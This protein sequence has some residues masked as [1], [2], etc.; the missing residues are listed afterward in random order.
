[1]AKRIAAK[2]PWI[3]EAAVFAA[4]FIL[5]FPMAAGSNFADPD[6]HY[7]LKISEM[8]AEG[9]PV[10]SFGWM[11][12]TT[13][14]NSYADHHFLYHL[15]LVPFIKIFGPLAG[16]KTA[17]VVFASAAVAAVSWGMRRLGMRYA[18][19]WAILA[20]LMNPFVFR[21]GLAKASAPGVILLVAGLVL[22]ILKKRWP[23]AAVSFIYVWT[24]GGWPAL[25]ILGSAAILIV[26]W[27][28]K[29]DS[30]LWVKIRGLSPSLGALWGGTVAGLIINPFFPENLKF[31][32]QQIVQIAVVNY[33]NVI[34]VGNEWY[35]YAFSSLVSDLPL[36]FILLGAAIAAF[37]V[38]VADAQ[39]E[40]GKRRLRMLLALSAAAFLFL[41]MTLRSRRH[42][43]YFVPLAVMAAGSWIGQLPWEKTRP[44]MKKNLLVA[45]LLAAFLISAVGAYGR[46]S[47]A[48]AK[49]DLDG[50]YG[51]ELYKNASNYIAANAS[52]G[53]I[54]IHAD[55]DQMP[56]LF[57]WNSNNRYMMGL[58]PTFMYN[59]DRDRYWRYVN[60]TMGKSPNPAET[61]R[62]FN[63]R[64]V[65]SD[66]GHRALNAMLERSGKFEKIYSDREAFIYRLK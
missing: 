9:G 58:D 50:R 17:T 30:P 25:L 65:L 18:P 43:E 10:R 8:I 12:F 60:F 14:A 27:T 44:F 37:P 22:A 57:Y 64:F 35:P 32:W 7:H 5:Y 61:M 24:H 1:M 33:Q 6:A 26:S 66:D 19:L 2:C 54:I 38:I 11:P 4:V 3:S 39:D 31:Y 15:A 55:W 59:A 47:L 40:R 23:L 29:G 63:S 28:E 46:D 53:E 41:F 62:E 20:G 56:P 21:I 48:R 45:S 13:L 52:P 42:V 51:Y 36:L 16:I 34:G 49:K